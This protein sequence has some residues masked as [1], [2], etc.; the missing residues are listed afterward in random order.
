MRCDRKTDSNTECVTNTTVTPV[1]C[2]RS[3]R[4][5]FKRWRVISS[6]AANGSSISSSRGS[7]TRARAIDTR[8]FMPPDS[9]RGQAR[10]KPF[11][12]TWPSAP[13]DRASRSLCAMPL[14]L[15]RQRDVGERG[16]PRHQGR[17]LED[18]AEIGPA[19]GPID[20]AGA[21][22]DESGDQAQQRGLAAARRA[23]RR[24]GIRRPA[25]SSETLAS[26]WTPLAKT[27]ETPRTPT[28]GIRPVAG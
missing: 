7:V 18:E 1:R 3:R 24:S 15:Q 11:S 10:S 22:L 19:R 12:P 8:I 17:L 5:A 20:R 21:G 9:S 4:S 6:R 23:R 2:Q 28:S 27:L 16:C 14:Q 13:A 25:T 26:A